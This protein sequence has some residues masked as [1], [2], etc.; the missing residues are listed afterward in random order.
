M[1]S[2][3]RGRRGGVGYLL[4]RLVGNRSNGVT[5]SRC[6]P[7]QASYDEWLTRIIPPW[8]GQ[9]FRCMAKGGAGYAGCVLC[10]SSLNAHRREQR[11]LTRFQLD[12]IDNICKK[13]HSGADLAPVS[14]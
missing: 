9:C 14:I 6:A 13:N 5:L 7:C 10:E 1:G 11:E 8:R 3:A 2:R 4:I 12:L